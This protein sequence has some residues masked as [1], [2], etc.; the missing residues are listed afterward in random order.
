MEPSTEGLGELY[1]SAELCPPVGVLS[2]EGALH[3]VAYVLACGEHGWRVGLDQDVDQH[4]E[5]VVS[6][7]GVPAASVL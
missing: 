1:R 2:L 3:E 6:P 4:G 5:Q 7:W